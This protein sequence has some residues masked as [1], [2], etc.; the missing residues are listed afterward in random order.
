MNESRMMEQISAIFGV[1][2][3]AFYIGIGLYV[4]LTDTLMLDKAVKVIFGSAFVFYGIYR[5]FRSFQ[6]VRAAFFRR[7]RDEE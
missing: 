7:D 5:G 1:F 4:A 6:K 3:T 2:M